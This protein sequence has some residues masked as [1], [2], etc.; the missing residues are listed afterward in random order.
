MVLN[1]I[2]HDPLFKTLTFNPKDCSKMSL[3]HSLKSFCSLS[4]VLSAIL[5]LVACQRSIKNPNY[6]QKAYLS[7]R[8]A[9]ELPPSEVTLNQPTRD[10]IRMLPHDY[11]YDAWEKQAYES[12]DQWS[13]R[14]QENLELNQDLF[15]EKQQ[16]YESTRAEELIYLQKIQHMKKLNVEMEQFISA[17]QTAS[18]DPTKEQQL[19]GVTI[20]GQRPP[21]TVHLVT[22]GETLYSI[23]AKYYGSGDKVKD[24]MLW[25]QGWIRSPNNLMAGLALVLFFDDLSVHSS[26][27][28]LNT[29]IQTI[30]EQDGA[31]Q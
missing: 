19:T 24:I 28:I 18:A 13:E 17:R 6:A 31:S 15:I 4:L 14:L 10:D 11:R 2:W 21:F 22:K 8:A 12:I 20:T 27:N 3:L 1:L 7:E 30:Q 26:Q 23:S 25:N 16:Q 9:Q 29:Y 5:Q